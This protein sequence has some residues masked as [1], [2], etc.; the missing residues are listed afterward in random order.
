MSKTPTQLKQLTIEQLKKLL[1]SMLSFDWLISLRDE[2]AETKQNAARLLSN[3]QLQRLQL[4]TTAICEIGEKLKENED[5]LVKGKKELEDKLGDLEDLKTIIEA[6]SQ[7][8][9][10]I[11][12]IIDVAF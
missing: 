9:Q 11:G 8:V 12:R 6:G 3:V 1:A 10:T 5:A 2:D 7:F 4:E